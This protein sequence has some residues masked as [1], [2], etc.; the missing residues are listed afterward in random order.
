MV[1]PQ[2]CPGCGD[3]AILSSLKQAIAES[4]IANKDI[5]VVSGI[6]CGS[7][8]PHF[9][10]TYGFEG[11]HGRIMPVA[12][13]IKFANHDLKVIAVGGDGD[14]YGIGGNHLMHS[15]R[16]NVDVTYLIQ[17]N[18]VYGLT[19]G[20][21]SPTSPK[22]MKT[23]SSPDGVK[24]EPVNPIA[25]ALGAGASFVARGSISNPRHLAALILAGINHKGFA[26]IDVLQ[27]CV[28]YNKLNTLEWHKENT[29]MLEKP[30]ETRQDAFR[31]ALEQQPRL[32]LGIIFQEKRTPLHEEYAQID[33]PLVSKSLDIDMDA[34]IQKFL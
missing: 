4:G 29:Y 18:A 31:L 5:V 27:T 34:L 17:N 15:A 1:K 19:K 14:G 21:Y 28:I 10:N 22:G 23:S 9:L 20:Q 30:A 11:L 2:W 25:L 33:K 26:L 3:F 16:K 32:P 13:G 6:G 7:K 24:E 12:T 8:T